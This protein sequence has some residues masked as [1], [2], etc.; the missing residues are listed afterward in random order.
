LSGCVGGR[1]RKVRVRKG[2][3]HVRRITKKKR[4]GASSGWGF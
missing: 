4:G 3:G 2:K 1:G